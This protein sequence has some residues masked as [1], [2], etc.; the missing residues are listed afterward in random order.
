VERGKREGR[1]ATVSGF[2][3]DDR[4]VNALLRLAGDVRSRWTD[5]QRETVEHARSARTQREVA[6]ARGVHESAVSQ[7][8]KAALYESLLEAEVAAA[9]LLKRHGETAAGGS[10][11]RREAA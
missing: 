3:D 6:A 11:I 8:L 5:V 4:P 2:G 9:D 1:W 10:G 7:A